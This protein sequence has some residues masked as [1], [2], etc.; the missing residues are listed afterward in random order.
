MMEQL[1]QRFTEEITE[2]LEKFQKRLKSIP[3][4]KNPVDANASQQPQGT[5]GTTSSQASQASPVSATREVAG[6][7]ISTVQIHELIRN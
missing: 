7:F 2:E 1:L 5:R 6:E 4:E 3:G